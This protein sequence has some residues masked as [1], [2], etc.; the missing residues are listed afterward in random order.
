MIIKLII[1]L[2]RIRL[3]LKKNEK[4]QFANQKSNMDVYYFTGSALMKH[5]YQGRHMTVRPAN[6]S[7]M[8]LLND[9]CKIKKVD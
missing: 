3:G 4:F 5:E 2:I 1:F 6:V 9:D 8:W 7:L